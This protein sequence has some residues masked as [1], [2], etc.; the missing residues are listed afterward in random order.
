MSKKLRVGVCIPGASGYAVA[1]CCKELFI[2]LLQV[3]LI[4]CI[5]LLFSLLF[6]A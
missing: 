3:F 2:Y 5:P 1:L 6:G 4:K